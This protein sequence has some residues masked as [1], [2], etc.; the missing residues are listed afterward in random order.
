MGRDRVSPVDYR[1]AVLI[2]INWRQH[3]FPADMVEHI[4]RRTNPVKHSP[5]LSIRRIYKIR[6]SYSLELV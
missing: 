6:V 2:P 3:S 1:P 4:L 5:Q